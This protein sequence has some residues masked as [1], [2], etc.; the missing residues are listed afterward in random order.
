MLALPSVLLRVLFSSIVG[1]S[2]GERESQYAV[3]RPLKKSYRHSL[4]SAVSYC[5]G[6]T[7]PAEILQKLFS[8]PIRNRAMGQRSMHKQNRVSQHLNAN[9]HPESAYIL[10]GGF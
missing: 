2:S 3:L 8:V 4:I 7:I 9:T 5:T 1:P 6:S 10:S